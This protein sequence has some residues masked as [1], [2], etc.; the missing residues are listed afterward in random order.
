MSAPYVLHPQKI[1]S[2]FY[3]LEDKPAASTALN[4]AT[5]ILSHKIAIKTVHRLIKW[6]D[7]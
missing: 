4:V 1:A 6:E 7:T 3:K 5:I 2:S